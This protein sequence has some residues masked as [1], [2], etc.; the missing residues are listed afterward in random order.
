MNKLLCYALSHTRVI[1]VARVNCSGGYLV[2]TNVLYKIFLPPT[3]GYSSPV[4]FS[5]LIFESSSME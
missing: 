1:M 2:I 5:K 3:P 4:S